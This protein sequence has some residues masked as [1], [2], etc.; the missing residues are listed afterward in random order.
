MEDLMKTLGKTTIYKPKGERI[1]KKKKSPL[2]HHDL[3]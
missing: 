1:Q 3:G 2:G